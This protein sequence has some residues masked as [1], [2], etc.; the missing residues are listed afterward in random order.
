MLR[1]LWL[2]PAC[3][4]AGFAVLAV[5]GRRLP[6]AA[7]AAVGVMSVAASTIVA[8]LVAARFLSAPPPGH[9]FVQSL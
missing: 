9:V 3:P 8:F 4:L 2:V 7:V 1:A 5:A 6:R